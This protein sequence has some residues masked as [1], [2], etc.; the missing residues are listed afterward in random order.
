M[1]TFDELATDGIKAISERRFDDAVK[2]LSG[3]LDLAP[4]RPDMNNALGMAYL[5]RGEPGTAIPYLERAANL[6]DAF[7]DP[8]YDDLKRGFL[9]GLASAYE[10]ADRVD[11]ARRTIDGVIRR[12]PSDAA[13]RLQLA[14]LLL[15]TARPEEGARVL[16]DAA[17]HL[18]EES[19]KTAQVLSDAVLAFIESENDPI[20]F[21]Q[22]NQESYCAYY[23]EIADEQEKEGWMAEAMRMVRGQ[24]GEPKAFLARGA[25]PYALQR[26]DLVNPADGTIANVYSEKEPMVVA[27]EG[28]EPLAEIPV[29]LRSQGHPYEVWVSSQSPWHWLRIAIQFERAASEADR[30]AWIDGAIGEWYLAGFNG[31]FGERNRGRFHY[32][33]DPE[34]VGDRG[35]AYV[36]DLGRS[37]V[38]A[39]GALL[40]RLMAVH[41]KTPLRKVVFG[42]GRMT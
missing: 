17:A 39:I 13:A 11:D 24:D 22:A 37:S 8:K 6:S 12:W 1:P 35:V 20:L 5:R 25:R 29:L 30:I 21:L 4:D 41:D 19:A 14:N 36:V 28:Y 38:D 15:S 40:R 42:F 10:L 23:D 32:I 7:A 9:V 16:R 26:I 34:P 2:S 31:E 33:G 3:A 18:D 27:L